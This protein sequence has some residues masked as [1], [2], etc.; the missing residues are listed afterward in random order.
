MDFEKLKSEVTDIISEIEMDEFHCDGYQNRNDSDLSME[1]FIL[2]TD[3]D[4]VKAIGKIVM[5]NFWDWLDSLPE[6][7]DSLKTQI[8]PYSKA[9]VRN[10]I[11][12]YL[13]DLEESK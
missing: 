2:D 3:A 13:H 10:Y 4:D 12:G 9:I 7:P 6:L 11:T 5:L 8:K 1:Y